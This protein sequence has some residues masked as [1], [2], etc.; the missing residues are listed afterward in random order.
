MNIASVTYL[1]N[2]VLIRTF[3]DGPKRNCHNKCNLTWSLNLKRKNSGLGLCKH[4]SKSIRTG[5]L[6]SVISILLG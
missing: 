6:L 3:W 4:V 5:S 1:G 2:S